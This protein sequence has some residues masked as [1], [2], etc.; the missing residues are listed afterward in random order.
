MNFGVANLND[1]FDGGSLTRGG[2]TDVQGAFEVFG[3]KGLPGTVTGG[4]IAKARNNRGSNVRIPYARLVPKVPIAKHSDEY[5]GLTQ[6]ESTGLSAG[7]LAWTRR[8]IDSP[9][10]GTGPDRMQ[11][12]AT[13]DRVNAHLKNITS[14][15]FEKDKL[16]DMQYLKHQGVFNWVP[17][18]MCLGKLENGPNADADDEYDQRTGQL[19]NIGVQGPCI[20]KDWSDDR[21]FKTMP[22]D[23]LFIMLI[24][25]NNK[26]D[27]LCWQPMTASYM[28]LSDQYGLNENQTLLGGYSVGKVL[29]SAASRAVG[30]ANK[31]R[32]PNTSMTVNVNVNL[33]WWTADEIKSMY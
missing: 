19:F 30:H 33:E 6:Y 21:K 28:N 17:D 2:P 15:N 26:E 29:D 24:S 18:G 14:S 3:S 27:A 31:V 20:T 1:P 9:F 11:R 10:S 12:L 32:T 8:E 23:R 16:N 13:T 7:C 22:L 4:K 25:T 5:N